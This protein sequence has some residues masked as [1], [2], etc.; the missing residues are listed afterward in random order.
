MSFQGYMVVLST[1][2]L[3]FVI[4]LPIDGYFLFVCLFRLG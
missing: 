4:Y 3:H 2:M 1:N